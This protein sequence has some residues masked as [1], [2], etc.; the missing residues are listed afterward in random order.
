M[1]Q[2]YSLVFFDAILNTVFFKPSNIL[3]LKKYNR[4]LNFLYFIVKEMQ[5]ISVYSSCILLKFVEFNYQ[6]QQFCVECLGFSIQSTTY[7]SSL[8]AHTASRAT[9]Y[10]GALVV[11]SNAPQAP[12]HFQYH[13]LSMKIPLMWSFS[14]D[15]IILFITFSFM[16]E[17]SLSSSSRYV[18]FFQCQQCQ[19]QI[20]CP[21]PSMSHSDFIFSNIIFLYFVALSSLLGNYLFNDQFLSVITQVCYWCQG[22]YFLSCMNMNLVTHSNQSSNF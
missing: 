22:D 7:Q 18:E 1:H 14:M 20:F 4:F 13:E 9:S 8:I 6:F 11:S 12:V 16:S 2:D 10:V 21:A 3:F 15:I 19:H 17:I 5:Q